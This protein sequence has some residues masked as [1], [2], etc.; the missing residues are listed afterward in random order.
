[1]NGRLDQQAFPYVKDSP[2]N[3]TVS[4]SFTE[5]PDITDHTDERFSAERQTQL[6]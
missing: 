2:T 4:S 3:L 5:H 1:V 6:A